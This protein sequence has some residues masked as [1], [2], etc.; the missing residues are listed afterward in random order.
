M[1]VE[2]PEG[3]SWRRATM[4][5]AEAIHTLVVTHNTSVVGFPDYTLDDVVDQL[6]EPGYDIDTGSWLVHDSNGNL[7]GFGWV[8]G[9]GTGE[10]ANVEVI[11]MDPGVASWLMVQTM[12]RAT[13]ICVAGGH[14]PATLYIGIY[15]TDTAMRELAAN[16]GFASATTFHRMRIDHD[17]PVPDPVAPPG[18]T[19]RHG[20]GDEHFRR[21][22]HRVL[23][24]S[25]KDHFGYVPTTFEHWHEK[26]ETEST[27]DWS[28]LTLAELNSEPVGV[29]LATSAFVEDENCGYVADIGVLAHARGR[30][31]A[32]FLLRHQFAADV[33]DGRVGTL[34]H[35]DTNNTTPA[36]G[37]Y[38][39]VGMRP[40]LIVDMWKYTAG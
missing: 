5:D 40:V 32:K 9:Q 24:E 37:V 8:H 38:E 13:E 17:G 19:L 14:I 22:A 20:P 27:F 18:V 31:V 28:Q 15:R 34:L 7:T 2:L 36:L 4:A 29:V 10:Y 30:G 35:V 16:H 39:S 33:R 12:E 6:G 23:A 1:P 26:R 25:F 3:L 11:T 21:T